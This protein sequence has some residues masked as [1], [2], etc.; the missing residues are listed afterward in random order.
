MDLE[1]GE[2]KTW[3]TQLGS[4]DV[5]R[6]RVRSG[7]VWVTQEADPVDHVL[8]APDVFE[9]TRHGRLVVF[10]LTPARVE[11]VPSSAPLHEPLAATA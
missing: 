11:V 1:L 5:V 3:S 6:I 2:S 10:G 4:A 8:A 9:S 7:M